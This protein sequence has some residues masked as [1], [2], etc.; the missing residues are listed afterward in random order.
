V[1]AEVSRV[2][3]ARVVAIDGPAGSGKSTLARH[4]ARALQLP[5][6]NTGLMYRALAAEALRAGVDA[7]DEEGLLELLGDLRF[8]LTAGPTPEL[9]V[10]GYV[11]RDL[12]SDEVESTV[13]IVAAH[14]SV[15]DLMCREQRALGEHGAVM[16]GRDIA[17]V[18]FPDARVRLYL[19]AR[20]DVRAA[21]RAAER[22]S[23]LAAAQVETAMRR[24][25]GIDASTNPHAPAAGA[26]VLDTSDLDGAQVLDAALAIVRERAPEL[27]A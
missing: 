8:E 20:D 1:S 24:R 18:V 6:V 19:D 23:A 27:I 22:A 15:R 7:R 2:T 26:T 4:L 14:Q 5:Y 21:R 17:S 12:T 10:E 3:G 11:D 16:E 9:Q 25:D 13:S